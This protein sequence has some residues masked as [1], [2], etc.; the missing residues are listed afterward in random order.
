MSQS[1]LWYYQNNPSYDE[2]ARLLGAAP[3]QAKG[4]GFFGKLQTTLANT[5]ESLQDFANVING[6]NSNTL[7]PSLETTNRLRYQF[8]NLYVAAGVGSATGAIDGASNNISSSVRAASSKIAE[9]TK[10]VSL[11]MGSTIG[12]LTQVLKDPIGSVFDLP[13]TIGMMVDQVNP[14][15]KNR[16]SASYKKFQLDKIAEFPKNVFGSIF[17]ISQMIDK[18]IAIPLSFIEDLYYGLMSVLEEIN[19]FVNDMF[20][21]IQ[22]FFMTMLSSLLGELSAVFELLNA[23]VQFA[24]QLG[25]IVTIFAGANNFTGFLNTTIASVNSINGFLQDPISVALSYVP[26][27]VSQGLYALQNPN[28]VINQFLPPELSQWFDKISQITGFGF[29][30]NMGQ[31]LGSVLNGLRDGVI[32]SILEGFATQFSILSPLFTG[33]I[34]TP[35][36]YDYRSAIATSSD[37]TQY[38]VNQTT[39]CIYKT[40]KPPT[41]YTVS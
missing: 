20:K 18:A 32:T 29:N 35:P 38:D 11:F 37:G 25:G 23:I 33:N 3:G 12:T 17:Q 1:S 2:A 36:T 15:F 6:V 5:N 30:G 4:E 28:A 22:E 21:L 8:A 13:N 9:V 7:K 27:E 40:A 19:N 10:P 41:N 31:G 16:Y 24:N 34:T 26:S 39:G 14:G